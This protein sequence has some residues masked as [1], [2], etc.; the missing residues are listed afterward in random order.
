MKII[1]TTLLSLSLALSSLAQTPQ[2]SSSAAPSLDAVAGIY[3]T[4]PGA[5]ISLAIF[6]PGDNENHL[7]FTD[8]TSG[9]IRILAP[10]SDN[11]FAAGPALFV[12][13]PIEMQLTF[14]RNANG[15]AT[16]VVMRKEKAPEETAKRVACDRREITFRNGDVSLAGTVTMPADGKRHPGVVMLHGSGPLNRYSFGPFPDFFVSR[17]FAVLV[18]DKRGTGQSK[19]NLDAA[20]L[21]DLAADG[22]AAIDFLNTYENIEP[23]KIGLCGTSQ[24]GFLAAA[25]AAENSSVA[26]IVNLYGM[27]VPVWQQEL[28]RTEAELRAEQASDSEIAEALAFVKK[29]FEVGT[30]GAGWESLSTTIQQSKEKKWWRH[31][32]KSDSLDEL[33]HYWDTLYSVDPSLPLQKVTCPVLALFGELDTS[34]PVTDS[35][36]NMREALATAHNSNFTSHVF[37][38]AG[39]GLLEVNSGASSEIPKSKRLAPNLWPTMDGWLQKIAR[40]KKSDQ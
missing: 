6:D 31:V 35:I 33:R 14:Q 28:Y 4:Q 11:T 24:G 23:G 39:H 36:N 34:T 1:T 40:G 16:S 26:F 20:T 17:G 8:L 19:G 32:T 2:A 10:G 30:T 37:P 7:L 13:S 21:K 9:A 5:F 27:Y 38:K 12:P 18:Y 22:K 29:E 3:T 15:E 25:V